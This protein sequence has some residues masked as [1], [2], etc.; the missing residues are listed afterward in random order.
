MAHFP[1]VLLIDQPFLCRV[2]EHIGNGLGVAARLLDD[3]ADEE[4]RRF[5]Q[6]PL[7]GDVGLDDFPCRFWR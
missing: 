1:D 6:H 7:F 4:A 5:N 3:V 2:I